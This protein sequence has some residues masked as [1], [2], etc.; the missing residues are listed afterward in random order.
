MTVL[1]KADYHNPTWL[2]IKEHLNERLNSARAKN[3]ASLDSEATARLRGRISELKY[4]IDLDQPSPS[5]DADAD[6][7]SP[8]VNIDVTRSKYVFRYRSEFE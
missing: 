5:I 1:T 8:F 4:L 2:K 7:Q 6:Y 3:D